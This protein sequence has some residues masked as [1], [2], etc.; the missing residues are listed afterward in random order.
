MSAQEARRIGWNLLTSNIGGHI[1]TF[2]IY[3]LCSGAISS[4]LGVVPVVGAIAAVFAMG[5]LALGLNKYVIDTVRGDYPTLD[6]IFKFFNKDGFINGGLISFLVGIFVFLWSLLFIIPGIIKGYAYSMSYYVWLDN[7]TLTASEALKESERIMNGHKMD[8]FVLQL[9]FIGWIL[10]C[11][12]TFGLATLFVTPYMSFSNAAFYESI[13][14]NAMADGL[15]Y[16]NSFADD[17]I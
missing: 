12:I 3:S 17:E 10:L 16:T 5:A 7:P 13:K 14:G 1:G 4:V 2:F 15:E 9:S 11:L 6:S 8:L